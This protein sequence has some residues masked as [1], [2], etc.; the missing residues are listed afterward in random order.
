MH[1]DQWT[2]R[3]RGRYRNLAAAAMMLIAG[4]AAS[5]SDNSTDSASDWQFGLSLYLWV[6]SI[7]GELKYTPP[8]TG[9]GAE[10]DIG[11]I[12][13]AIQM[14]FMGSFEVRKGAWSGFTDLLYIDMAGDRS[15]S[16]GLPEGDSVTLADAELDFAAWVWTLAGAY[17]PWS[18]QHS[19]VDVLLGAR[20]LALDTELKLS[21]LGP[22]QRERTLSGSPQLW[23]G[24][25]GV[26]GRFGLNEHWFIPYYADLGT[27]ETD[28]TWQMS[29]GIGYGF[30]W[31]DVV[32]DYRHLQY[33]Q[34]A[35]NLILKLA[36]SGGRLGFVFRF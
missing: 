17:T 27:G 9:D 23:D 8:D 22:G 10:V 32:L 20:L 4:A 24:I 13:D 25:V 2:R 16:V 6:P 3:T 19:R 35:D 31:G 28:Y 1:K 26:K 5:A 29:G 14:V 15:K 36:L 34:S 7:S 12:I 11:Q 21:G 30:G 18:S 33:G